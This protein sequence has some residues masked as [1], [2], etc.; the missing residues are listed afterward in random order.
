[1]AAFSRRFKRIASAQT[2]VN[3]R[4]DFVGVG[5]HPKSCP[6][7]GIKTMSLPVPSGVRGESRIG[8]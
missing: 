2:A 5:T 7:L 3:P 6:N 4:G 1:M 8:R